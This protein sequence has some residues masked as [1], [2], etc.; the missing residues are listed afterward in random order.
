MSEYD[1]N[2][3]YHGAMFSLTRRHDIP[4]YYGDYV[5]ML[6]VAAAVIAAVAIPVFGDLL[7]FSIF[8]QVAGI[9]VFVLL[10]GLTNPHSK[11]LFLVDAVISGTGALF[12]ESIAISQYATTPFLLFAA[13]EAGALVLLFAFYYSVKTLRAM[14]LGKIGRMERPSEFENGRK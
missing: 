1:A 7:P 14:M 3:M 6:F 9:I 10:A 8:T 12:L 4:H 13:R 11:T 2:A 5:R